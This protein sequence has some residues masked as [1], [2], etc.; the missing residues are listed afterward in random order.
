MVLIRYILRY[1]ASVSYRQGGGWIEIIC[2]KFGPLHHREAQAFVADVLSSAEAQ[3]P[4]LDWNGMIQAV[5]HS[6][7]TVEH[8]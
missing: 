5:W 2:C 1:N 4:D 3:W 8:F 7:S 6:R